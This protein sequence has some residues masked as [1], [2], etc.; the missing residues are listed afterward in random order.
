MHK[1]FKLYTSPL[2]H[3]LHLILSAMNLARWSTHFGLPP[4]KKVMMR[5]QDRLDPLLPN[6]KDPRWAHLLDLPSLRFKV[7]ETI[8]LPVLGSELPR[9]LDKDKV[10]SIVLTPQRYSHLEEFSKAV[11]LGGKTVSHEAC[12][13]NLM[14][15]SGTFGAGKTV[16]SYLIT[17]VAFLHGAIV[18]YVVSSFKSPSLFPWWTELDLISFYSHVALCWT[19]GEADKPWHC[20]PIHSQA[21]SCIQFSEGLPN[22]LRE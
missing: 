10:K 22:T 8:E 14:I 6:S 18:I 4:V 21:L 2:L 11:N 5:P 17:S 16:E 20:C 9:E 19:M 3:L 7:G 13:N 15:L 12:Q 1:V